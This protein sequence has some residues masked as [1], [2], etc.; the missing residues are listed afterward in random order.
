MNGVYFDGKHSYSDMGLILS[1]KTIEPPAPKINKV[2]VPSMNGSIDLTEALTNSVKYEDRKITLTFT[3]VDSRHLWA[4]KISA[5]ENYLHGQKMQIMFD[6]DPDYYYEGRVV[7]NEWT[8]SKALGTLNIECTVDPFKYTIGDDWLWDPFSFET[9][10]INEA[11]VVEVDGEETVTMEASIKDTCPEFYATSTM[12][13]TFKGS[14]YTLSSG[15]SKI[16]DIIFD[17]GENELTFEGH[18]TVTILYKGGSL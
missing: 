1:S 11:P 8:S 7:V 2:S 12:M 16:Y 3:V 14:T 10:V 15:T 4:T 17:V 6:D 9:G 18:G 5:I 13:V